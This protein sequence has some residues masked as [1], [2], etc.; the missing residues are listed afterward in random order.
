MVSP[1]GDMGVCIPT[2]LLLYDEG[3][4]VILRSTTAIQVHRETRLCIFSVLRKLK[5]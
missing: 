5:H 1:K 2:G 4:G 3:E